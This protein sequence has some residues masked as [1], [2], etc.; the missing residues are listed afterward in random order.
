M[1]SASLCRSTDRLR[2][3]SH[4]RCRYVIDILMHRA[5][6]LTPIHPTP[7]RMLVGSLT[8]PPA[9]TITASPLRCQRLTALH[10]VQ[11]ALHTASLSTPH[12]TAY[13]PHRCTVSALPHG[14]HPPYRG[15][16]P[17]YRGIYPLPCGYAAV[18]TPPGGSQGAA[19]PPGR[20]RPGGYLIILQFGTPRD[21]RFLAILGYPIPHNSPYGELWYL[22]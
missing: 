16:H 19:D 17:P 12:C 4:D 13:T 8:A 9:L 7:L 10:A 20:P 3:Y 1:L 11:H 15:I 14:I 22:E 18:Y 6:P 5:S 2:W 21:T